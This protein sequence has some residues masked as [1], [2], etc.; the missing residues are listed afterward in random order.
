M[1][2]SIKPFNFIIACDSYKAGHWQQLPKNA[3]RS[4]VTVV[5]RKVSKYANE[6]VAMGQTFLSQFLSTV[7]ITPDMIDEAELEITEQGYEF[8]RKGWERIVKECDGKLP[9]A[10]YGVEEGRVVKP[11]TPI[12]GIINTHDGYAWLPAYV[13]TISQSIVWK[14]S[15]VASLCR[16]IKIGIKEFMEL[17]GADMSML[18]Y[19]LHNFGDRGADSPNEAPVIAGI[20]HAALFSG[21]DCTRANGY[22][23]KLYNTTKAYTSSVEA[24]EHSVMCA[25]SDAATKSDWGAALMSIDRLYAVVE[26]SKRGIGIP[27]MSVV[28][29]TYD[30]RRFVRD[31]IGT[32][33]KDKVINSGG[34][35]VFRPDS[36]DPTIEP[37][38]VGRDIESTF[39]VTI[40]DKGYKVL[41]P[42]TAVIQGDGNRIDTYRGVIQGWIDAGFSM[43]NF[44]LGM[45]SGIT[46]DNARD[47]FSF[48]MKATAIMIGDIWKRLSKDPVTDSGKKSLS[49][50]VR[51]KE[52]SDGELVVYDA[53]QNSEFFTF[54]KESAGWRCW[55][56]D[57]F[58]EYRQS[59]DEV[60][61]RANK[62][63]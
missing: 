17:T 30:S 52:D 19:K 10:V 58:R 14:M 57:G 39:G 37:G 25:N 29:D 48:S 55:F 23:K 2:S 54:D 62:G 43:D 45:G 46:H 50:L 38:M 20:A 28:I 1:L 11:Q 9:L 47:D 3:N 7:R 8:N 24:T 12:V 51:C 49:G 21:S 56:R 41:K 61:Q 13:E 34:V 26:R 22:I 63:I 59:F 33:L 6:I 15:T 27:L 60:R 4:Y 35:Y 32:Q 40:N 53:L 36:G 31:Y 42:Y 44:T 16:S 18:D 5:P